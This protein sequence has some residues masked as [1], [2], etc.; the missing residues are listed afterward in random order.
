[1]PRRSRRIQTDRLDDHRDDQ[2]ASDRN[3]IA[4]RARASSDRRSTR[5]PGSR[6]SGTGTCGGTTSSPPPRWSPTGATPGCAPAVA[7]AR[8]ADRPEAAVVAVER[9]SVH[10]VGST[11]HST[12]IGWPRQSVIC[13]GNL[14]DHA[15]RFRCWRRFGSCG[16]TFADAARE[17]PQPSL[18]DD[19]P[20]AEALRR[21]IGDD[22][23]PG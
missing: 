2:R 20:R 23:V 5:W 15:S 6:R 3:R 8:R 22:V 14:D 19:R 7:S 12:G 10:L 16:P 9:R 11:A 13:Q 4:R 18:D 17:G 1:M 21:E